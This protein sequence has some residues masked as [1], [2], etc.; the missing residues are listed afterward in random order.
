MS[1]SVKK[2]ALVGFLR[3]ALFERE[4]VQY[5]LYDRPIGDAGK[6]GDEDDETTVPSD[7]PIEPAEMMA[8]QLADDRPPIE[9]DEYVPAN[10]TELS[11]AVAVIAKM[12][13]DD[14][15]EQF[16][17]DALRLLDD[18]VASH[19][20]PNDDES[21]DEEIQEE[22]VRRATR[23]M[24]EA[25]SDWDTP[26]YDNSSGYDEEEGLS[27]QQWDAGDE[28]EPEPAGG[29]DEMSFEDLA[30]VGGYSSPSGARQDIERLLS[31]MK[32]LGTELPAG[33]L[34]ALRDFGAAEFIDE[35]KANDY[36]DDEDVVELQQN[37]AAVKNLD[38]FRFF[39]VSAILM[40]AYQEVKRTARKGVEAEIGKLGVPQKTR[41][42]ILNQALGETPRSP[43]KLAAKLTRDYTAENPGDKN[44]AEKAAELATKVNAAMSNLTKLAGPGNNILDLAKTRWGKQSKGRR[45][46]SLEQALQSTTDFQEEMADDK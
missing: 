4:D 2:S 33:D 16:Y 1:V 41:Q 42:T 20:K 7:V 11:R 5:G 14:K 40:P 35:M 17:R 44:A 23:A 28:E 36:L 8:T 29:P 12:V 43:K 19:N 6:S 10:P 27:V 22:A 18:V 13:P 46:K 30:S 45:A 38:S 24:I 39:F 37:L 26:R 3:N 34:E 9:D 25:I 32:Y 15:V 31:R 21:S